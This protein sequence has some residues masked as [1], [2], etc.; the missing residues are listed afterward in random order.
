MGAPGRRGARVPA[1]AW[2]RGCRRLPLWLGT[3]QWLRRLPRACP[4]GADALHSL[5]AAPARHAA[6][7]PPPPPPRQ[8]FEGRDGA[9]APGFDAFHASTAHTSPLLYDIDL[10]G[11][12]DI[13]LATYDGDILFFKDTVGAAMSL[14]RPCW[15]GAAGGCD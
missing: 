4:R 7:P 15:A 1:T 9:K 13:V 14:A 10:D 6:P 3:A 11:V 8:V 12:P 5:A 2:R